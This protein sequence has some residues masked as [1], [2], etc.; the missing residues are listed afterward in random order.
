M[1]QLQGNNGSLH[2]II[3]FQK[4]NKRAHSSNPIRQHYNSIV[5]GVHGRTEQ[6]N[7]RY[8]NT[9]LVLC[10]KKQYFYQ[11]KV[12]TGDQKR[13]SRPV[14]QAQMPIRMVS[15]LQGFPYSRL[16]VG[17]FYDRQVCQSL[18]RTNTSLQQ[19]VPRSNDF[20]CRRFQSTLG[21]SQQ[22]CQPA[23][24]PNEQGV[25]Q[26][27]SRQSCSHNHMPGLACTSLV[28][29][30]DCLKCVPSFKVAKKQIHLHPHE[31]QKTRTTEKPELEALSLESRWKCYLTVNFGW[32][33]RAANYYQH[34]LASSTLNLYNRY[35]KMFADFCKK[36]NYAFP[37]STAQ[38]S[39][40]ASIKAGNDPEV[41]RQIGRWRSREVF[42]NSYVYPLA[43]DSFTD[44]LLSTETL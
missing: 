10:S 31:Y 14:V 37:P 26:N 1:L 8:C 25:R 24:P 18:N 12:L 39:A 11:F 6:T 40:S 21:K 34:F 4:H 13:S 29:K 36:Y 28:S 16:K 27:S 23:S 9:R 44:N 43:R 32:S 20:R 7:I 17:T 2:D 22:F 42:Y 38:R 41:T 35:V 30:V 3:V 5:P 19:L 33:N 15:A